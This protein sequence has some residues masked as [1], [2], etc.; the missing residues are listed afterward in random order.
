MFVVVLFSHHLKCKNCHRS[1]SNKPIIGLFAFLPLE[2]A[3]HKFISFLVIALSLLLDYV[4]FFFKQRVIT[5][6]AVG[7]QNDLGGHQIF[8]RKMT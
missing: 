8:A 7:A 5:S 2:A 6:T 1:Y 3:F 4:Q